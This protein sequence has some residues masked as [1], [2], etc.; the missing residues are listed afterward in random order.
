MWVVFRLSLIALSSSLAGFYRDKELCAIKKMRQ[1]LLDQ[2]G[3][4]N[5]VREVKILSTIN[6][7]NLVSFIG[8]VIDPTVLIVMEFIGGGTLGDW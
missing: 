5:F 3:F 6:H 4:N 8:F 7:I 1:S 2:E